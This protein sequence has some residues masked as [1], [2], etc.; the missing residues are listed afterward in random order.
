MVTGHGLDD[1]SSNL[2][3]SRK[4]SSHHRVLSDSG[5]IAVYYPLVSRVMR[6]EPEVNQSPPFND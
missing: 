5:A 2:G 6:T 1:R 4:F 3:R